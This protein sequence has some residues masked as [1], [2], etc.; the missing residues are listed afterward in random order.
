MNRSF[1]RSGRFQLLIL[2]VVLGLFGA[3]LPSV[4][5]AVDGNVALQAT[6]TASSQDASSGSLASKDT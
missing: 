1:A 5:H 6:A 4:A 3:L 2:A